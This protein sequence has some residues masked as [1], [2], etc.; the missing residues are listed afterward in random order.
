MH[1]HLRTVAF[2]DLHPRCLIRP[3]PRPG[4]GRI[5][6]NQLIYVAAGQPIAALYAIDS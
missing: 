1:S 5:A 4:V 6:S 3:V 2:Q